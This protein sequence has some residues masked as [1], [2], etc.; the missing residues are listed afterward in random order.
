MQQQHAQSDG[1][2]DS[3]CE[4]AMDLLQDLPSKL[5]E[6]AHTPTN[7]EPI[8]VVF[9]SVHTIK[10]NAGFFE[11]VASLQGIASDMLIDFP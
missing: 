10:G 11:S 6:F 8:N 4:E 3:F 2:L 7:A 5:A 9:R 1:L